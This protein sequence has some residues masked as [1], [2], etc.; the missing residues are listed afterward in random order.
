[1]AEKPKVD[2]QIT[3]AVIQSNVNVRS[4]SPEIAI[5]NLYQAMSQATGALYESS[6]EVHQQ[7]VMFTQA[8]TDALSVEPMAQPERPKEEKED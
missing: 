3:D 2:E 4:D 7:H 6:V 1:M 5:G 8:T